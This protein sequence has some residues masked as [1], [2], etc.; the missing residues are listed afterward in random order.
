[1][2]WHGTYRTVKVA[3]LVTKQERSLGPLDKRW[4]AI[5]IA[6][7]NGENMVMVYDHYTI[8]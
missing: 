3:D 1:M 8:M 7:L 2:E 5:T 4:G 6:M